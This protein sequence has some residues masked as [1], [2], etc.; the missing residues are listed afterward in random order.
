MDI[1]AARTLFLLQ[2]DAAV[3]RRIPFRLTFAEWAALVGDRL[4]QMGSQPGDSYI[5]CIKRA[6]GYVG[7][8]VRMSTRPQR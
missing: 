6:D 4:E 2:R 5:E 7:G 1:D 3:K 8:N